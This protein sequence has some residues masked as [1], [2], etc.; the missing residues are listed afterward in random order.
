MT[1]SGRYTKRTINSEPTRRES[2]KREDPKTEAV[3]ETLR[4]HPYGK[5]Y[6]PGTKYGQA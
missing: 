4:G 2:P 3:R 1:S 5:Q 6:P